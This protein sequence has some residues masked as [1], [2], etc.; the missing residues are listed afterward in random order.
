MVDY[1]VTQDFC[2]SVET[3]RFYLKYTWT[4]SYFHSLLKRAASD[5]ST[6]EKS[7]KEPKNA[8]DDT[9]VQNGELQISDC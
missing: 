2:K 3:T 1:S 8:I 9:L 4:M 7:D 5:K 6:F